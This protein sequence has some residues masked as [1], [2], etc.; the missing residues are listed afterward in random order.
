VI[1]VFLIQSSRGR[2]LR[3]RGIKGQRDR[4]TEG[5]E[6]KKESLDIFGCLKVKGFIV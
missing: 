3:D 4:G 6:K 5:I 2:G 1:L